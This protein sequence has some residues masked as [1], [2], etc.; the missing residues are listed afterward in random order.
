GRLFQLPL[1]LPPGW[2]VD[3][4]EL[5]Q[6][7]LLR[8]WRVRPDGGRPTL[9]VDLNRPLAAAVG[10]AR[11]T[12]RLSLPPPRS[13]LSW[14]FPDVVP[15][16]ARLREGG[17]AVD[18]DERAFLPDIATAAVAGDPVEDGPW[19]KSPPDRFYPY[20]GQPVAGTLR[21]TP[22]SLRVAARCASE[23][24]LA[25]GG[26]AVVAHLV[27]QP[28]VGNPDTVDLL[29]SA[30]VARW[31]WRTVQGS[32]Q[33]KGCERLPPPEEVALLSAVCAAGRPGVGLAGAVAVAR[34]LLAPGRPAERGERWRL[35]LTRPLR[36]PVFLD[37]SCELPRPAGGAAGPWDVPL[38]AVAGARRMEG[39]VTLYLT[40]PDVVRVESQGLSEAPAGPRGAAAPPWRTFRY[41]APPV[42]LRLRGRPHAGPQPDAPEAVIDRASLTTSVDPGG[43]LVHHH[44]FRVANWRQHTLPL[45]LPAG[46]EVLAARV[47]GRWLGQLATADADGHVVAQLPI[48]GPAGTPHDC[49][50]AHATAAPPFR[51]WASLETPPSILPVEPLTLRRTWRLPPGL[52]PL[53]DGR[54]RE[55]PRPDEP[56]GPAARLAGAVTLFPRPALSGLR[57]SL[58]EDDWAV[59][60]RQQVAE[61]GALARGAPGRTTTLGDMVQRLAFDHLAVHGPLVLDAEALAEAGLGPTMPLTEAAAGVPPWEAAGLVYV[62]CRAAPLLTTRRQREAWQAVAEGRGEFAVASGPLA[63][64][65]AEAAAN[66]HDRSGR[67][68]TAAA[69]LRE[70][71][72]DG[73]G[74]DFLAP[75]ADEPNWTEWEPTAG[76]D[77]G[78][79]LV[80]VRRDAL[81]VAGWALAVLLAAAF[82]RARQRPARWRLRFLVLWLGGSALALLWLPTALRGLAWGPLLTGVAAAV[83]WYLWSIVA[84]MSAARQASGQSSHGPAPAAGAASALALLAAVWLG[85]GA[86]TPAAEGKPDEEGPP[87]VYVVPAP[88]DAPNREAVLAP[89]D[90]IRH[91]R[92]LVR[93]AEEKLPAAVFVS[94]TYDGKVR[95]E[96]VVFE[97]EY[98]VHCLSD[99]LTTLTLPLQGVK[100]EEMLLDGANAHPVAPRPPQ[101]GYRFTVGKRGPHKLR[102][103]FR[104]EATA[105]G[106]ESRVQFTAP[107]L[108]QGRLTLEAPAGAGGLQALMGQVPV[109]GAQQVSGGGAPRLRADLGRLT[110]PLAVR[111]HRPGPA[112]GPARLK[113]QEMYLWDVG[114]ASAT[115]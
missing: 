51:L 17:L 80:V 89:P 105:A 25:P 56:Q 48:P 13:G 62:P 32:N 96:S 108:A 69:W 5:S 78:G 63:E 2:R 109:W 7:G 24:V 93:K 74:S 66:G 34:C 1:G 27:L 92:G 103:R 101:A 72:G 115:L 35:T 70:S 88:A 19:G 77:P 94:A 104:V 26:A 98:H 107:P 76:A 91:L 90:L 39:E 23:V 8:D 31:E 58:L 110:A 43:R 15:L 60:Q 36:E 29:V 41:G 59:R 100:L 52:A 99:T 71:G 40:G 9:L 85:T 54:F 22:L 46:A 95:G 81:P 106:G 18:F 87:T 111:W 75:G 73:W 84:G 21:L 61:A 16:G 82:W 3:R 42:S 33:V 45:R 11:L 44:R 20:H 65:V 14:A 28:D 37:A 102:L 50:I 6:A 10:A 12:V 114:A 83:A 86:G 49:E 112:R 64:A 38:L 97:A 53:P 57:Q 79:P 68:Q 113:V 55:L 67:F 30:P 47:D 4:V